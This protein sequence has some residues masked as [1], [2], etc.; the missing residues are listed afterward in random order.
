MLTSNLHAIFCLL[1][2]FSGTVT[3]NAY[4]DG[5]SP[6]DSLPEVVMVDFDKYTGPENCAYCSCGK[7][8][9]L[10]LPCLQKLADSAEAW[11]GTTIHR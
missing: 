2:G 5:R 4:L 7:K 9:R 10:F 3:D 6:K 1:N 11:W 8:D